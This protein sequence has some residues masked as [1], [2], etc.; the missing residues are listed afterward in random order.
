[1]ALQRPA[2]L[3][4][5]YADG[6]AFPLTLSLQ[7]AAD[8]LGLSHSAMCRVL[9]HGELR[10]CPGTPSDRPTFD[11]ETLD[12]YL[13]DQHARA[14]I[15]GKLT[16]PLRL[17]VDVPALLRT[18]VA[19]REEREAA[20]ALAEELRALA[21][22][23]CPAVAILRV[24]EVVLTARLLVTSDFAGR[25]TVAALS[26]R[27]EIVLEIDID[28]LDGPLRSA[29]AESMPV[30]T[31]SVER[32]LAPVLG[33]DAAQLCQ[34]LNLHGAIVYPSLRI[35]TVRWMIVV[36]L[37]GDP[38]EIRPETR[39]AI[40]ALGIQASVALEAVR[41]RADVLHR[42]NRAE[43]LYGTVR[44]LA[45]S[46]DSDSLLERISVLAVR[47]LT[48]DA[49]VVLAHD[50]ATNVFHPA[51]ESGLESESFDW[52]E[53]LSAAY[54]IGRA[55]GMTT[56]LQVTD[57]SRAATLNMPT[58]SGNRR[59]Q[60]ATCAPIIHKGELLGAIEVYSATPRTFSEDDLSLL[61][62]FAH[63]AAIAIHAVRSQEKRRRALFGAVEA[64]AS[65]NEARDGY[66]G[67]H[68]KRLADLAV[69]VARSLGFSE[70]EVERVGLA[71]ALHDIG[72][73]AVPDAVLRKPG[74]LTEEERE[75][76]NLHP[77]T[78]EEIV[79]RV[80]ELHDVA[81]MIG[82]HQERWDGQG[83][84]RGLAGEAIPIGARIIAVVDTYAALIEDRPYRKG[85]SH[86]EALDELIKCSGTQFDA[87]IVDAFVELSDSIEA[88]LAGSDD[89]VHER[90]GSSAPGATQSHGTVRPVHA[91]KGVTSG[92]DLLPGRRLAM[93]RTSELLALNDL[94]RSIVSTRDLR[95][96]YDALHRQLSD[97][98]DVDAL[99]ILLS[100][101]GRADVR[102]LPEL[103]QAPFFPIIGAPVRE[104]VVAPVARL[105]R[106]L[107]VNDYVEFMTERGAP[108]EREPHGD[109]P[110]SVISTPIVIDGEFLGVLSVQAKHPDAYDKRHVGII[111]DIALHLGAKL[112]TSHEFVNSTVIVGL[113]TST[114]NLTS[115]LIE[116]GD[117]AAVAR[118]FVEELCVEVSFDGCL[119]YL[120]E[121]GEPVL[122]AVDGYY[123]EPERKAY[124]HAVM[125]RGTGFIWSA[126]ESGQSLLVPRLAD[127]I[128]ARTLV[129]PP[130]KQE[131]ALVCPLLYEG[132][133]VGVVFL[134]RTQEPFTS[135]DEPL[136]APM[137]ASTAAALGHLRLRQRE[138]QR[139]QELAT[140]HR[141]VE[142][143][144]TRGDR[145]SALRAVVDALGTV[146]G[147]RMVSI[148]LCSGSALQLH[149]QVGYERP[150]ELVA[151]DYSVMA[152]AVKE[153]RSMLIDDVSRETGFETSGSGVCSVVAAPISF[154]GDVTGVL[155]VESGRERKLTT[156]DQALIEMFAQQ[157]GVAF[158]HGLRL[159]ETAEQALLDPTTS[160][161]N[162]AAFLQSLQQ[163]LHDCRQQH[164]PLSLL[165]LDLDNF[166]LANDAFGHRFGDE[167]LAWIGEFLP[168][169]LP[170][171][172]YVAR[173]GGEEFV[174]LLP[175]TPP[176]S[177][178]WLAE[179]LRADMAQRTFATSLGH[180]V[181]LSMSIGVAGIDP[182]TADA[183]DS[184]ALIHAA[185]RAMYAAKLRGRNQVVQWSPEVARFVQAC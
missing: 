184:E 44:M 66:T 13:A 43:A 181:Q 154:Q 51:G 185:D 67:E 124:Q 101:G 40:E 69:L 79:A 34:L 10:P 92:T 72:K 170:P 142:L 127:D 63:Q 110:R 38:L 87:R 117:P 17:S 143:V 3:T 126:I 114:R 169:S 115:R 134:T 8:Y 86:A 93:H 149:A 85:A 122:V 125:P 168:R 56:P 30:D 5:V 177:A 70:D 21:G 135:E 113:G 4:P 104:G 9:E 57:A 130:G 151:L 109:L 83:Y 29:L 53:N 76:I 148:Y 48:A 112:R 77:T 98:L 121:Q 180:A 128:R 129:R 175:K 158:S 136:L 140:L 163:H 118:I 123:T 26:D 147:Y 138:Q 88:L 157:A 161:P 6:A 36:L 32:L 137:A 166:K 82:A 7:E 23:R 131:S 160:L 116:L 159:E 155:T 176:A 145:D 42:A 153:G 119:M 12:N 73:I 15:T 150:P 133:V 37:E 59:A 71:A 179:R 96:M 90:A 64:L 35:G 100:D 132:E 25:A 33:A 164:L 84:P 120:I 102:Q 58:L 105:K 27:N 89:L 52:S 144:S 46:E 94:T 2:E 28:E 60:A 62:A 65:A 74:P 174:V 11:I 178:E 75:I 182:G 54:L 24:D 97:M 1:V 19:M 49:A 107:W 167:L 111:E 50:P 80:P 31:S 45:R 78:G 68:C 20:A 173:Y 22:S 108:L 61:S 39:D 141:A 47:L 16:M 146:F 55:A 14:M 91:I 156:W 99:L 41:L 106:T 171:T 95:K 183:P 103:H 152:R 165:F 172:A 139:V 81:A 18:M 162:Q